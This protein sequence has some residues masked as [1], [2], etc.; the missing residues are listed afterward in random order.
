M[1][2][3][4]EVALFPPLNHECRI[5]QLLM[6]EKEIDTNKQSGGLAWECKASR[7]P[8]ATICFANAKIPRLVLKPALTQAEG[9]AVGNG[10][11]R[12]G[13]RTWYTPA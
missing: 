1:N 2:Q 12:G 4:D 11:G 3:R 9:G 8:Q 7:L 13:K 6:Q 10:T 5:T